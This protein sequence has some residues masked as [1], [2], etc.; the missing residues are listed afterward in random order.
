MSRSLVDSIP[1]ARI[2]IVL[3]SAFGIS[4]GLCGITAFAGG[5]LH[6]NGNLAMT[7]GII[8]LIVMA[9]S[10]VALVVTVIAWVILGAIGG[11]SRKASDP[12]KLFDNA[13][14][15]DKRL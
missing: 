8:E 9:L 14:D 2:V 6:G 15:Q 10:A 1:F 5:A 13:D 4:L 7:F 12:Q 11:F 3:A